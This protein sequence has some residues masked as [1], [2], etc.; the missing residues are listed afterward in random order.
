LDALDLLGIEDL[1]GDLALQASQDRPALP[2]FLESVM[3]A[4]LLADF[5]NSIVIRRLR[6]IGGGHHLLS[7]SED[8]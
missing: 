4:T 1:S 7:L 3:D 5:H 6:A 2:D 8:Y